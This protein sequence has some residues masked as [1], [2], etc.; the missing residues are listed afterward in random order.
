[1][2]KVVAKSRMHS[3]INHDHWIILSFLIAVHQ[4]L[5]HLSRK[6]EESLK[7]PLLQVFF[8][9]RSF[10][11]T[12]LRIETFY[13][14]LIMTRIRKMIKKLHKYQT[15]EEMNAKRQYNLVS[16]DDGKVGFISEISDHEPSD[17][18]PVNEFSQIQELISE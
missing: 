6:Y 10:W 18:N 4:V 2:P 15:N 16:N 7:T 11:R 14:S 1:M 8:F 13:F 9:S 17:N 5:C 12:Q 3:E